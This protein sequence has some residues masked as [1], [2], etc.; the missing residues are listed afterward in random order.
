MKNTKSHNAQAIID[1][2]RSGM[3]LRRLGAL[4]NLSHEYV[5]IILK[6]SGLD[7]L[8]GGAAIK[9]LMH[10]RT[11]AGKENLKRQKRDERSMGVWGMSRSDLDAHIS[12]YGRKA[13]RAF[14]NQRSNAGKRGIQWNFTFREWWQ[15]WLDSGK[16]EC[17][18]RHANDFVMA[19]YGDKD[20]PYAADTVYIC[21]STVNLKDGFVSTPF[22]NRKARIP[23]DPQGH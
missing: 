2:Y 10:I 15:V 9:G 6:S 12:E 3:S 22:K 11:R 20:T 7:R 19:R 14:T 5:R 17:R 21:T 8:D 13:L 4:H 23:I 16:W 18:G 1:G